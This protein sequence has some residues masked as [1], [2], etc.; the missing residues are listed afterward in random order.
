[1]AGHW[2]SYLIRRVPDQAR[3]VVNGKIHIAANAQEVA[4]AQLNHA[5]LLSPGAEADIKPE[6]EIYADNVKANHGASIGRPDED[7]LF[8]LE[9]RGI[10]PIEARQMLARAF[11]NDVLMKIESRDLRALAGDRVASWL[12]AFATEMHV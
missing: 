5:L 8:Y 10:R 7:K 3:G 6:L 9:S 4:S 1:M 11:V 2:A 12:P